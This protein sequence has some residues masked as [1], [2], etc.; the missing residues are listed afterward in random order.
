MRVRPSWQVLVCVVL[1]AGCG[2]EKEERRMEAVE[3]RLQAAEFQI[4]TL[5]EIEPRVIEELNKR[6]A[7]IAQESKKLYD[8]MESAEKRTDVMQVRTDESI[9]DSGEFRMRLEQAEAWIKER[10][11]REEKERVESTPDGAIPDSWKELDQKCGLAVAGEAQTTLN[12]LVRIDRF[13]SDFPVHHAVT[14]GEEDP[15]VC[16]TSN[17]ARSNDMIKKAYRDRELDILKSRDQWLGYRIDKSWKDRPEIGDCTDAC[18]NLD[19]DGTW[20]GEWGWG[21]GRWEC[22]YDPEG[23][24]IYT[25]R[26]WRACNYLPG[27]HD[28]YSMPYLMQKMEVKS[29]IVP[30]T[31]YCVVDLVWENRI[32][33]LSHTHYPVMQI[34]LPFNPEKS[35]REFPKYSRFSILAIR[36]WDV[37]Y[38]DEWTSS[39]MVKGV[40]T[41]TFPGQSAG[42]SIEVVKEP[43][44][45]AADN[46]EAVLAVEREMACVPRNK[47]ESVLPEVVERLGFRSLLDFETQ[48]LGMESDAAHREK[49]DEV[50]KAGCQR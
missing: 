30:D 20:S 38:K 34:L 33:C 28:F 2:R 15:L 29:M 10:E 4:A 9:V 49:L 12:M 45:C 16:M 50:R 3:N 32:Y 26:W 17:L 24:R 37:L 31:L 8:R 1:L 13:M 11:K 22:E 46:P 7:K 42:F 44:C 21:G 47:Q 41:P 5:A 43:I 25:K 40:E 39:W 48:R 14:L 23:W 18:C 19:P 27:T 35:E 36:N 6:E